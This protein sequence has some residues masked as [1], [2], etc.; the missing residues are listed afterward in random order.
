MKRSIRMA[1]TT[2]ACV[3]GAW[4]VAACGGAPETREGQAQLESEAEATLSAMI[5]KDPTLN[6]VLEEAYG[7]VVFP[8]VGSGGLVVGGSGGSGVVYQRGRPVGFATVREVDVGAIAGG[9]TY[10]ELIV[11]SEPGPLER[12][13]RGQFDLTANISATAVRSGAAAGTNF[14]DGTAVFV[15]DQQGLMADIS[16]GGQSVSFEPMA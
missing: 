7:Y 12:L 14:R 10:S 3:V 5:R 11:F 1:K 15:H 4:L 9:Q 8:S 13:Q 2:V 6:D 16:V